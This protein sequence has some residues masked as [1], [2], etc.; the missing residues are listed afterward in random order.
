MAKSLTTIQ[1]RFLKTGLGPLPDAARV[2]A[3]R[4]SGAIE[5]STEIGTRATPE[6]ATK[7]LYRTMWVDPDI[8]ARILDIRD[9]DQKDGRIKKIHKR[10]ASAAIKGGLVLQQKT[11]SKRVKRAWERFSRRLGFH[12]REKLHSDARGLMMEGNLPLQWV[13]NQ[14]QSQVIQGVRMPTETLLPVVGANGTF[15][16]PSQAYHQHDL[17]TG[18]LLASFAL[19]QLSMGRLDPDNFDDAGSFGRP[20]LDASRTVWKQLNM[21]E[22]DLVLRRRMRAPQRMVHVLKGVDEPALAKYRAGVEADQAEGN[23]T[24]YYMNVEGSVTAVGGDANLDQIADVAHLLDTFFSGSPAPKGLFGFAGDLN[25]D[26]LEDLKR[27][28]FEEVD[29]LQDVQAGVYQMGFELQLLLDGVHP[30]N[31]DFEVKFAERRTETPN[32]ATDRALKYQALGASMRTVWETGLLD[33][34]QELARLNEQ[35]KSR[36]PYPMPERIGK[37]AGNSPKVS[38]TPGNAPKGESATSISNT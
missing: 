13:L 17:F 8:R 10:T 28:F 33:P 22:Q 21:T 3:L 7:Y 24:D 29:H 36:D 19:W 27:D 20:Y 4:R 25:R 12:R 34:D 5:P 38:V 1:D 9:M 18:Q 15:T 31:F 37:P 32:Q 14:A 23:S 26:I 30:D 35:K 6:N 11:E 2:Q 16:D